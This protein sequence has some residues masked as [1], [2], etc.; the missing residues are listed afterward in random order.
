MDDSW[1]GTESLSLLLLEEMEADEIVMALIRE[2]S[3]GSLVIFSMFFFIFY[4]IYFLSV[5][6]QRPFAINATAFTG[7]LT[8]NVDKI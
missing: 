7:R 6:L 1:L 5:Q 4:F 3:K 2:I 8:G